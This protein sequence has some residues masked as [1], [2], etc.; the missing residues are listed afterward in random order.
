MSPRKRRSYK[1]A[2]LSQFRSFCEVCR[3]GGYAAAAREL[4]LTSPA[5]WEQMQ[6]LE[7][8]YGVKLLERARPGGAPDGPRHTAAGVDS[9]ARGRNRLDPGSAPAGGRCLAAATRPG[10]QSPRARR[11]DQRRHAGVPAALSGDPTGG[12]LHGN[13]RGR[14]PRP[15]RKGGRGAHARAGAGPSLLGGDRLR[16]GRQ[17]R[18][19]P[20]HAPA[21]R[22]R[23]GGGPPPARDRQAAPRPGGARGVFSPQGAGGLPPLRPGEGIERRRRDEQRRIHDLVCSFRHGHRDHTRDT[24]EA[25]S[26]RV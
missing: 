20:D 6:A 9:P 12:P 2:S 4:M 19:P 17:A 14:A 5:V 21:P 8:H 23:P 22:A 10:H 7:H 13:R 24:P 1:E 3:R 11:G 16:A 15:G 26:T 18:L 25:A